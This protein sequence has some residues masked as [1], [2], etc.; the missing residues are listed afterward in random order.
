MSKLLVQPKKL[1]SNYIPE[2]LP[3]REETVEYIRRFL[4]E[5][6]YYVKLQVLG[7]A[8]SGKTSSTIHATRRLPAKT[9]YLNMKMLRSQ[10]TAYKS[11][12]EQTIEGT[13]SRSLSSSEMLSLFAK[14]PGEKILVIDEIDYYLLSTGDTT[15]VY[16]LTRLIEL[17]PNCKIR[18]VIFI[19]RSPEWK[20]RLDSAEKSSLGALIVKL[21]RYTQE[22]L[23]DIIRYRGGG[24]LKPNTLPDY[25]LHYIAQVVDREFNGDARYAL[26]ILYFS[27]IMAENRDHERIELDDVREV[28]SQLIPHMTS[29][30]FA[31]LQTTEKI[32]LLSVAYAV[33]RK[34]GGFASFTEVY[35]SYK[36]LAE[37]FNLRPNIRSMENALQV[38]VDLGYIID[39]GPKKIAIDVPV[40][41][42]IKFLEKQ[43]ASHY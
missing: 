38:L 24:A 7:P 1:S 22:Q 32:V 28:I 23:V 39:K 2:K 17:E 36:E 29:E 31:A 27:A 34:E 4:L 41:K 9:I 11:M 3:H 13:V 5:D 14:S 42:L 15:L 12:L 25:T 40:D 21:E 35:N 16:D 18:G 37:R 6:A 33:Q 19:Y 20:K 26:D 8:G 10:Y 30:D 43:L